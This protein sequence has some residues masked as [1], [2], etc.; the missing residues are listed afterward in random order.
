[1]NDDRRA[2]LLAELRTI[3]VWDEDYR[4]KKAPDESDELAYQA[5]QER[6]REIMQE[7]AS[8]PKV[9]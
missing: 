7:I 8:L 5:R 3:G 4:Q 1:M 6:R 9:N 2:T